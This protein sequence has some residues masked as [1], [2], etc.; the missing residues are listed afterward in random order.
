MT[1]LAELVVCSA[2]RRSPNVRSRSLLLLELL[3][4][5]EDAE[6]LGLSLEDAVGTS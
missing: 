4:E 1:S 2:V 6:L 3:H 5:L